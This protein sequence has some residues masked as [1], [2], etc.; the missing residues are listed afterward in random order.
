MYRENAAG[1]LYGVTFIDHNIG[2]ILNDS[3]LGKEYAANAP[4]THH[5]EQHLESSSIDNSIGSL[6]DMP[7]LP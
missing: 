2:V 4:P 5:T 3:R 7:I 6:F 1:R